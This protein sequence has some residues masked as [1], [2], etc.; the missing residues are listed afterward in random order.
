MDGGLVGAGGIGAPALDNPAAQ[1]LLSR[2][3]FETGRWS[4]DTGVQSICPSLCDAGY[5][6]PL[7]STSSAPY[8][9][10]NATVYVLDGHHDS[11]TLFVAFAYSLTTAPASFDLVV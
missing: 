4:N 2:W 11:N 9:C 5:Y 1:A 8:P 10:G 3:I 7:G 6:C